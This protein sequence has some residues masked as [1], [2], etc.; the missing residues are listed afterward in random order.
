MQLR[1]SVPPG[2]LRDVQLDG[3]NGRRL[4][5]LQPFFLHRHPTHMI[6]TLFL[7]LG[8]LVIQSSNPFL[9]VFNVKPEHP[10]VGFLHHICGFD[11]SGHGHC[12]RMF[13]TAV[14]S[15][16]ANSTRLFLVRGLGT[17]RLLVAAFSGMMCNGNDCTVFR[18]RTAFSLA[19]GDPTP[20]PSLCCFLAKSDIRLRPSGVWVQCT[21]FAVS[22]D[23]I[24]L[25]KSRCG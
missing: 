11:H 17:F 1:Q 9:A 7:Q 22:A 18:L 21:T 24:I 10:F 23:M 8:N 2:S 19:A 14:T 16:S 25:P 15:A 5:Q 4:Q 6:V 13:F 12:S 20:L 3:G